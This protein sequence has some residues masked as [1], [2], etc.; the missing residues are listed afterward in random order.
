VIADSVFSLRFHL[1]GGIGHL[2]REAGWMMEMHQVNLSGWIA[3]V[4][5]LVLSVI[6][7]GAGL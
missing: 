6:V 3:I 4:G 2:I 1:F 7:L 5:S